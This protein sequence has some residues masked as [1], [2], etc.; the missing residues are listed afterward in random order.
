MTKIDQATGTVPF[1]EIKLYLT[2][3]EALY[4]RKGRESRRR[5][6]RRLQIAIKKVPF[7]FVQGDIRITAMGEPESILVTVIHKDNLTHWFRVVP[8]QDLKIIK[9][10]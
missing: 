3:S 7:Q 6:Q 1:N 4:T 10:T 5:V 2:F 9:A 8:D